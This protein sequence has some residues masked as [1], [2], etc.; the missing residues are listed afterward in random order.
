M[1]DLFC[2]HWHLPEK[3]LTVG[4][5]LHQAALFTNTQQLILGVRIPAVTLV[6]TMEVISAAPLLLPRPSIFLSMLLS[7]KPNRNRL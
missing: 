6:P 5:T 2:L 1:D 4:K 7:L 3:V